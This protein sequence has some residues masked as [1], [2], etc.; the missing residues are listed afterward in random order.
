M[1]WINIKILILE[2]ASI[3]ATNSFD[4]FG[5]LYA[6]R[7]NLIMLTKKKY[8]SS[9]LHGYLEVESIGDQWIPLTTIQ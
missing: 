6:D 8:Q 4:H 2:E 1:I 9:T 3:R 5:S 7:C